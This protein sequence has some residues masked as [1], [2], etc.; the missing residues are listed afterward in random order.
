MSNRYCMLCFFFALL[1][2]GLIIVGCDE[3]PSGG[4]ASSS[5]LKNE[6]AI[7]DAVLAI[8]VNDDRPDGITNTF[9]SN[10]SDR[11]YLWMYWAHV[12]GR[13]TVEVRWFSPEQGLD[14]P[15][16]RKD[17]ETF[18]SPTG[19]QITWFFVDRPS[20]GFPKGEWF[21]EVFL[22]TLFERSLVFEVK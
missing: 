19:E 8:N 5:P 2:S 9:F 18:S 7:L 10:V 1:L 6:P 15:P 12:P 17:Q 4:S 22:D 14:E 3:S 16:F 13:H 11:I 21:V 20:S